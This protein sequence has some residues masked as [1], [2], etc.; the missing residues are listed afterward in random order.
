M[1]CLAQGFSGSA[2]LKE[3][4]AMLLTIKR[5][6]IVAK[7]LQNQTRPPRSTSQPT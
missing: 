7:L 1:F 3:G 2:P 4:V 5:M 6:I